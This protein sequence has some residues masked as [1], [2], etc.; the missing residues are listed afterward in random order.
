MVLVGQWLQERDPFAFLSVNVIPLE[1]PL[2]KFC[3]ERPMKNL[4]CVINGVFPVLDSALPQEDGI[5]FPG[6][7]CNPGELAL[8]GYSCP[9]RLA[10]L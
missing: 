1:T 8:C 4:Y 5:I 9:A 7:Q 2:A 3:M 10:G 6:A